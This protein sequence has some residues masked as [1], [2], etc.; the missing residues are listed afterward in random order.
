M[1]TEILYVICSKHI[2]G[3]RDIPGVDVKW[4][5]L[6]KKKKTKKTRY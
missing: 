6:A 2:V 3:F 4:F 1:F 5:R